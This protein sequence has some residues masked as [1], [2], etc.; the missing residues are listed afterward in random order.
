MEI[1]T[2]GG[3][4]EAADQALAFLALE[5]RVKKVHQASGFRGRS[6]TSS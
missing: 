5:S 2:I 1:D 4:A 3:D 6:H